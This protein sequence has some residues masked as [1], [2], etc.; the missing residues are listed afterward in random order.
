MKESDCKDRLFRAGVFLS[1]QGDIWELWD[2]WRL[3]LHETT[4]EAEE[5]TP[6]ERSES[7]DAMLHHGACSPD[8]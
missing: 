5:E 3:N 2:E 1:G 4:E 6:E 7:E 8:N